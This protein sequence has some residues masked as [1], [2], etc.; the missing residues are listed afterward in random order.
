MKTLTARI[1]ERC[2]TRANAPALLWQDR[3]WSYDDLEH[4]SANVAAGLAARGIGAGDRVALGLPNSPELIAA[5]LGVLRSG[6]VLVPLNPRYTAAE[7][8]FI[9]DDAAAALVITHAEQ[10]G[11]LASATRA[12]IVTDLPELGAAAS[13][14]PPA[15]AIEDAA[16][17][18]Y[19]SGTTGRPKGVV[20]SHRALVSNLATVAAA[21]EW[22]ENDRLL[23]TL[24]CFHVHGLG[25]GVLGSFAVGSSIVLRSRF[26]AEEV[27]ALLARYRC[28][29]FF[30]VPTMYNRLVGLPDAVVAAIDPSRMRLWVS[31]SAPLTAATFERFRARFGHELLERFG[32]TEGGFMIAAPFAGP[33]RPGVVGLPLPGIDVRLI[34]PD[35][36]D[37]GEIVPVP[38]GEAGEIVIRGPNLFSGYWRRPEGTNLTAGRLAS[39]HS[40]DTREAFVSG[41]FR[42][43]DLAVA[44][45]DGMIRIVGRRSVDIIKSRGFKISA[46]EIENCL[47]THPAV[48][49]V[50]VVGVPHADQGEAVV[51]AVTPT[52]SAAV[53]AE[54]LRTFACEHLAPHKVPSRFV[55]LAEIPRTGPGKFKKRE[56]IERLSD[57]MVA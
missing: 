20:L 53:S 40:P 41:H 43:G 9:V 18:V 39:S 36:A 10:A 19:T 57:C 8:A 4:W 11:V 50:A 7:A 29:M 47:Q 51:A 14:A 6:A 2:R 45:A 28:T 1:L 38:S 52:E 56:L 42:S 35:R 54:E 30:G 24:P 5:V 48:A 17:I 22:T 26:V 25:L 16:M 32:M 23:L 55:F 3:T 37:E 21:W 44:E 27:P 13:F 46:V 49:E 15:R 12:S 33:R 34:D 31:G